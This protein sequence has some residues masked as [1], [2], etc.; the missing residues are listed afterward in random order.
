ML[1]LAFNI[2]KAKGQSCPH[3]IQKIRLC[4]IK[5]PP[6]LLEMAALFLLGFRLKFLLGS[7]TIVPPL[8]FFSA[9]G[10]TLLSR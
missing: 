2:G 8:S 5:K 4:Q 10:L 9:V 1:E 3:F 6:N 7:L